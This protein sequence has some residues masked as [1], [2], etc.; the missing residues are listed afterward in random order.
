[1][2]N[3]S[4]CQVGIA[5]VDNGIIIEN[6]SWL[7]NPDSF[8]DQFNMRI[9]GI[10]PEI[11]KDSPKFNDLWS[12]IKHYF[13]E[14]DF[15]VAH[16]AKFDVR[17]LDSALELGIMPYTGQC[18]LTIELKPEYKELLKKEHNEDYQP[19]YNAEIPNFK[20]LC[21]VAMARRT[22]PQ[23][24]SYGLESLCSKLGIEYGNHDA[25]ADAKSCAEL[26]IKI[27]Q[28]KEID[29]STDI[30]DFQLLEDKLQ[31]F[32]GSFSTNGYTSSVCKRLNRA[33]IKKNITGDFEKN[34]PDSLFYQKNVCF[35]G[36]LSSMKRDDAQQIIADIGGYLASGVTNSTNIL[37]VGQQDFRIVGES[38][39]SSK[40]KKAIDIKGKGFDIEIMSEQDFLQNI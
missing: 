27:F 11:V 14:V 5:V 24:P 38:G 1:M 17:V 21:S 7:V 40:Q 33:N 25:G 16:N 4:I 20:F 15:V 26:T 23:E 36:T 6:K 37:V 34:N 28:E 3:D 2:Y 29:M 8:F 32:F 30:V 31:I 19:E 12:E 18:Y 9:H 10:T 13:N 22:Y 39:M 35:T